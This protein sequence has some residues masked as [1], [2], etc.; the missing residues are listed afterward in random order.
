MSA[1]L[2]SSVGW[3]VGVGPDTPVGKPS[4]MSI[5]DNGEFFAIEHNVVEAN[6][7]F[8]KPI[9]ARSPSRSHVALGKPVS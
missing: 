6:Q 1:I 5:P 2:I 8:G 4:I 3:F 7:Q 9:S